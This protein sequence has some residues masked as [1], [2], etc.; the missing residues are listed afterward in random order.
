MASQKIDYDAYRS[1]REG[2]SAIGQLARD[3][4]AFREAYEAFRSGE[5]KKFQAVLQRVGLHPRCSLLCDWTGRKECVFLCLELCGVPKPS[6]EAPN[7]RVLAEAIVR[8]TSNEKLVR[9]LAEILERRDRDAYRRI[10][11]EYKLEP[12]CHLFCHWLCVIRYRL[13]CRWICNP[14]QVERPNLAEELQA[15]RQARRGLLERNDSFDQGVVASNAGD[16]EKLGSVIGGAALV[17]L[18]FY[19]CEWFCS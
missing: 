7:P 10:V 8:I 13:I 17:P 3:E 14:Q 1:L 11:E 5:G 12:W 9:E 4:K 19:I 6:D 15:A 2:A 16:A 18:C